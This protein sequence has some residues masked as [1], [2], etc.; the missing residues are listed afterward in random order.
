MSREKSKPFV[1]PAHANAAAHKRLMEELKQMTPQQVF[2]SAVE[3]GIY[4]QD[5]SLKEPYAEASATKRASK[6]KKTA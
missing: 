3:A 5:G 2:L 1:L 4:A 6:T